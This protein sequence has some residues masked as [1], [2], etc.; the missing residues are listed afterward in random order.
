M[1]T[2]LFQAMLITSLAGACLAAVIT[3]ARPVTKRVF[4]Y[5]WH[6][7]IW[8]AVLAVMLLP[9]QFRLPARMEPAPV[10]VS[11]HCACGS[12]AFYDR[13]GKRRAVRL[14]RRKLHGCDHKQQRN[15]GT[16]Q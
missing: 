7:Y 8:L 9:V 1:L 14:D 15:A 6:D 4:G 11:I 12:A 2:G 13:I 5:A 10:T 3:L 16:G